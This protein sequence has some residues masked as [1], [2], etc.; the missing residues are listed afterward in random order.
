MLPAE[1][2]VFEQT[3]LAQPPLLQQHGL[4][5]SWCA[6]MADWHRRCWL[7]VPGGSSC[8]LLGPDLATPWRTWSPTSVSIW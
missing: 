2:A 5:G 8:T 1:V 4:S 7:A 6:A 3:F